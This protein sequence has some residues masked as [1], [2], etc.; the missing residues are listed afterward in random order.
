[1]LKRAARPKQR[2]RRTVRINNGIRIERI[3]DSVEGASAEND[4]RC[5]EEN[6]GVG[7]RIE[8]G[9]AANLPRDW[10]PVVNDQVAHV[11]QFEVWDRI[12]DGIE[13][14]AARLWQMQGHFVQV[15]AH[16]QNAGR[17]DEADGRIGG[18]SG[19]NQGTQECH[20]DDHSKHH[21]M[22]RSC[23]KI[24]HDG[25]MM[26]TTPSKKAKEHVKTEEGQ[27]GSQPATKEFAEEQ[28]GSR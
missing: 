16:D 12:V 19:K 10:R 15:P 13:N 3:T 4:A 21:P 22:Q 26:F 9:E 20:G 11:E 14:A 24:V 25:P 8:S 17:D 28:F 5:D 1:M 6:C 18:W 23:L 2:T 27:A 7:E